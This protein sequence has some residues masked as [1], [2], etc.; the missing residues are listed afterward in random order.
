VHSIVYVIISL[1]Q[2]RKI[3]YDESKKNKDLLQPK[4][5]D[6]FTQVTEMVDDM[7]EDSDE[8]LLMHASPSRAQ[9]SKPV[10][11]IVKLC[12]P[13]FRVELVKKGVDP[14]PPNKKW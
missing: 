9:L 1:E 2:T 11:K 5:P 7:A 12:S 13:V 6:L 10:N 8:E 14:P 3:V 4:N